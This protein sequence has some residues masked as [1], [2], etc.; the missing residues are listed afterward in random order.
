MKFGLYLF[1]IEILIKKLTK[2]YP[3]LFLYVVGISQFACII[4]VIRGENAEEGGRDTRH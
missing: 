2:Y 4:K 3:L 1:K